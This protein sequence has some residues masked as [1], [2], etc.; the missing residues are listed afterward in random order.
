MAQ[1]NGEEIFNNYCS[2]CHKV[3]GKSTGPWMKGAK[4]RWEQNS[5]MENLYKW[6]KN[7]SDVIK[8]GDPYAVKLFNEYNQSPMTAQP[9]S[10]EQ[11]DAV[12][13]YV[14]NYVAPVADVSAEGDNTVAV[15]DNSDS[16]V[17]II[18]LLLVLA[19]IVYALSSSKRQLQNAIKEANGEQTD[20]DLSYYQ[21]FCKWAGRH[22]VLVGLGSLVITCSILVALGN[23]AMQIGVFEGYNPSQPVAFDHSVHAGKAEVN[24]VYCHSSAEKGRHAGIPSVNVCMNCHRDIHEGRNTGT[25]EIAKIHAAAGFDPDKNAY[26][27]DASP[28][29]WNRVHNLP[30]HVYF[31]HSQHVVVGK[32][33]CAQ[34]HGDVKNIKTGKIATTADLNAVEENS[35]KFTKQVLTMGWCLEC[36]EQSGVQDKGNA[37]YDEI[38]KRLK[39]NPE[40]LKKYKQDDKITVRE[41]GGWECAKC[42]Y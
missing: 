31:N 22:K 14:D 16:M 27:K 39:D 11:I 30:D 4:E 12:L 19:V 6:V 32:I 34:C 40:L 13:A 17:W 20:E 5:S 1:P 24:C 26:T 9:L 7:S 3:D 23:E 28:I 33:D 15:K 21:L 18:V 2:S 25:E 42:H 41:L 37:Y 8:A 38:H 29:V 36:H 35:I 10:N